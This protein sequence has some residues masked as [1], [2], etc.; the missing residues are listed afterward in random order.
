MLINLILLNFKDLNINTRVNT[1]T[2]YTKIKGK[3]TKVKSIESN[4]ILNE[5]LYE[6]TKTNQF[7]VEQKKTSN[8]WDSIIST[9]IQ[10]N[11]H[12][13]FT[14]NIVSSSPSVLKFNENYSLFVN[15]FI[16]CL[17]VYINTLVFM[18]IIPEFSKKEN[19][20]LHGILFI[21]NIVDF[22]QNICPGILIKL[23][24]EFQNLFMSDEKNSDTEIIVDLV[25]KPLK[26]FLDIKNGINYL[27]KEFYN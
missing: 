4:V 23:K 2:N 16:K 8:M 27:F 10:T 12:F 3:K 13:N 17:D 25:F 21:K 18:L 24:S 1:K 22:N 11:S 20:H 9:S 19:I 14:V 26:T 7:F 15:K 6:K 5:S